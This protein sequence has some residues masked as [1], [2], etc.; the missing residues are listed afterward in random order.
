MSSFFCS[1]SLLHERRCMHVYA[2]TFF[3]SLMEPLPLTM[4]LHPVSASSCLAVSPRGPRIRP[5]KLNCNTQTHAALKFSACTRRSRQDQT[6]FISN[7]R[8]TTGS[9]GS[10]THS[11]TEQDCATT[12]CP[13]G[14]MEKN[15]VINIQKRR[16]KNYT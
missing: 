15:Y 6:Y 3:L 14:G 4:I 12:P 9:G 11:E 8:K 1:I 10:K 13:A 7:T 5:T 16:K 2:L